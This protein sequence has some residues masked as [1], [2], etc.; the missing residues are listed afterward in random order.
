MATCRWSEYRTIFQ[1]STQV[2][3][4]SFRQRNGQ[5]A[6]SLTGRA[7]WVTFWYPG[8]APHIIRA[9]KVDGANGFAIYFPQGD[10]FST[11]G[12]ILMQPTAE[13]IDVDLGIDR[14]FCEF[15]FPIVRW[16]V[17]SNA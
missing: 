11:V 15:S 17:I 4:F 14:G 8:A 10:E 1:Y 2:L 13:M 3:R 9:C 5:F 16:H 7:A 6:H 12:D